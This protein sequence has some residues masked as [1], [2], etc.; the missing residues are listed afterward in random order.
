MN[1]TYDSI[2]ASIFK[3]YKPAKKARQES[4]YTDLAQANAAVNELRAVNET[5]HGE[6]TTYRREN[7]EL[8]RDL[9][10]SLE[11]NQTHK[12]LSGYLKTCGINPKLLLKDQKVVDQFIIL[13]TTKIEPLPDE[14]VE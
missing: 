3:A 11:I 1:N 14:L 5:L 13:L 4:E 8:Q 12:I 7:Y 6:I 2:P 10:N 9:N